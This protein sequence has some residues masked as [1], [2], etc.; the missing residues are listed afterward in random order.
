MIIFAPLFKLCNLILLKMKKYVVLILGIAF[1]CGKKQ[2]GFNINVKL[3][4][5]EGKI[6]L[7]QR[8]SSSWILLT[9]PI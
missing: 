8:G 7:E 5:A 2:P 4:G 1:A 6:L 3:E 9:L